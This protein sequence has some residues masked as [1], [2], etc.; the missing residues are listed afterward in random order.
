MTFVRTGT[1][2]LAEQ[3]RHGANNAAVT[4]DS[5]GATDPYRL[6]IAMRDPPKHA[7]VVSL[8]DKPP[9]PSDGGG[10]W[11]EVSMP[12]RPSVLIW[13]GRGLMKLSLSVV[14]DEMLADQ[15]VYGDAY[16]KL[17]RFWR[18]EGSQS[19]AHDDTVEPP[20][21]KLAAK[22]DLVPYKNL[23]YVLSNLEWADATSNDSGERTQQ[24]LVLTFTEFRADERLKPGGG[25]KAARTKPYKV[26]KGEKLAQ[27]ARRY[28]ITQKELGAMQK[29]P[30]RDSRNVE[31]KTIIV[32]VTAKR[33]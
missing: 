32:P 8:H 24:I 21:L 5:P 6:T 14:I 30:I 9:T 18:P 4:T 31:G 19:A 27:I 22:G 7:V 33:S 1:N 15:S 3:R 25:K 11:E 13:K 29:P 17:T 20:V 16:T 2:T 12:R 28:G 10:G 26:K 23:A